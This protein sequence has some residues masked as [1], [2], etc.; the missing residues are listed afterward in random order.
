M[1]PGRWNSVHPVQVQASR[2]RGRLS[3]VKK[4]EK[5]DEEGYTLGKTAR[6]Q[7]LNHAGQELF[8][9]LFRQLRYH[10]S[11]GPLETL[12]RLRELCRW[13]MRPDVLSKAQMLE[14]LVLEQFL[15]IL[16]GEL[17]TWVQLHN[18]M[19]GQ[20]VVALLEELQ[21][22]MGGMSQRDPCPAQSPDVHWLG[23]GTLKSAQIG[24]SLSPLSS[25]SVP[26]DRLEPSDTPSVQVSEPSQEEESPGDQ[27][28]LTFKDVEVT[29]SQDEWGCLNSAQ[30]NL[31]QDVMLEN[32]GTL[33]SLLGS[34]SKPAVISWLEARE[35]WGLNVYT[36]QPEE[37]TDTACPEGG[38]L[39]LQTSQ[40]QTSLEPLGPSAVPAGH[41][42]T[43]T[44][45]GTGLRDSV[46]QKKNK[47][48]KACGSPI[49]VRVKTEETADG[50]STGNKSQGSG[51]SNTLDLK[52]NTCLKTSRKK[53]SFKHGC[54]RPFRK[55]SH[56]YDYKKYGKGLRHAQRALSAPPKE[57]EKD[58]YGKSVSLPSPLHQ[59][60]PP[61]ILGMLNTSSDCGTP[62][63]P[64]SHLL[65]HPR[66]PTPE[67]TF[68]CRVCEKAFKWHSNCLRHEKIHTGVKP[69]KCSFCEK[70]FLRLSAYRLHQHTHV[71]QMCAPELYQEAGPGYHVRHQN[72]EKF[73]DC[74]HCGKSFHCKSYVLEHQR[75]HTKEKPYRCGR[76]WKSFRWRSNFNRHVRQ[77]Q[78][79]EDEDKEGGPQR[80]GSQPQEPPTEEKT[81]PRPPRANTFNPKKKVREHQ[82]IQTRDKLYQCNECGQGFAFRSAFIVHK[83]NHA[84]QR[85]TQGRPPLSQEAAFAM[86]LG[87]VTIEEKP[88]KCNQCDKVFRH[89]SFL[90]IHQRVHTRE[91][92]YHCK[93]CGKAFR[94]TSNLYRHQRQ[95]SPGL[96]YKYRLAPDEA[97]GPQPEVLS[98]GKSFW[99]QECGKTFTR[100]RSLL[101]HMGIHSGEKRYKCNLCGK[102]YDRNYRLLNHQRVHATER[103]FTSQWCGKDFRELHTFALH[104]KPR[105]RVAQ[106][107]HTLLAMADPEASVQEYKP[108]GTKPLE[109]YEG[110]STQESTIPALQN[111]STE[112]KRH[113]CHLCGKAF[114][115]RS[116]LLSHKRFHTR[117]R[118]FKCK[119]CG[120]TFRW[121]SNLARHM[122]NH[123]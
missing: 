51:Q 88:Y 14:L 13:W 2:G 102:S 90:L 19:S 6:P 18:P 5:E 80:Q 72:G 112:K 11:S 109:S 113:K 122:K 46:E 9:Q 43:D 20:E 42:V 83:K 10:E 79:E 123:I 99:C 115:K 91:K 92:P 55:N 31:Y 62:F 35:P 26:C 82:I 66:L 34:F 33:A 63:H 27:E 37:K 12:S 98:D 97:P 110:P 23:T 75:I 16:P 60:P 87:S 89:H 96:H 69:Y 8:R 4:E 40:T 50:P 25:G 118:P 76:C 29:F 17:R 30:R 120:K 56:P 58:A 74:S 104:Q 24:P 121:T 67:K 49:R 1:P 36:V 105:T 86:P 61:D 103:P 53:R 78:E 117:E 65:F 94:W 57:S 7:T 107:K 85:K 116:L 71:K 106:P 68:K 84:I 101:D 28:V 114:G 48:H 77:H 95:H 52:H 70:A 47:V 59:E 45:E 64:S 93:E 108:R 54:G 38:E 15:S 111:R 41:P 3:K 73:L 100:K 32:Y 22:D 39:Q 81:C 44:P 119:V 21:R